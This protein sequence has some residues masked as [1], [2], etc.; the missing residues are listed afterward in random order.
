MRIVLLILLVALPANANWRPNGGLSTAAAPHLSLPVTSL[1]ARRVG[2]GLGFHSDL[3]NWSMTS[4][5]GLGIRLSVD[6]FSADDARG[7]DLFSMDLLA[8]GG[9]DLDLTKRWALQTWGGVGWNRA[10]GPGDAANSFVVAGGMSAYR[11]ARLRHVLV[12]WEVAARWLGGANGLVLQT[13]PV[14]RWQK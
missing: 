8:L 4:R 5:K 13:G 2:V 12:G 7:G 11:R 3:L 9:L 14:L 1:G 6:G 10:D